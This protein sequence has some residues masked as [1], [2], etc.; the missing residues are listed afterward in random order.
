ML[1]QVLLA[2]QRQS[3]RNEIVGGKLNSKLTSKEIRKV[4]PLSETV[5]KLF[6]ERVEKREISGRGAVAIWRV[7]LTLSDLDDHSE[8][9]EIHMSRAFDFREEIS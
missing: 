7:A 4:A 9:S 8:I 3:V 6:S 5:R 1:E 2:A